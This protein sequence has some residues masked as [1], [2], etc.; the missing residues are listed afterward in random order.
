MEL[1]T[2]VK[3]SFDES[4]RIFEIFPLSFYLQCGMDV[5]FVKLCY[6]KYVFIQNYTDNICIYLIEK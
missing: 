5:V 4:S 3:D 2:S 1:R 6:L